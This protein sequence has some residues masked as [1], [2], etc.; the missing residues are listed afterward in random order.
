MKYIMTIAFA[1]L[2]S[3]STGFG[4]CTD[5]D[6]K[7]LEEFDKAWGD[8]AQRGDRA[9]LEN[10]LADDCS[11]IT[12]TGVIT[13]AQSIDMQMKQAE[14]NRTNPNAP[15]TVSDHYVISCSGNSATI[16]HR[17]VLTTAKEGKST[18]Q[19]SRSIHFLEKR[20][21]KWMV[22]SNVNHM[23][24]DAAMLR[25]LEAEWNDADMNH[26]IA[27][28]ENNYASDYSGV[29]SR[30]GALSNKKEDIEDSK[31]SKIKMESL[32]LSELNV[33]VEGD[34]AVVT[35]INHVKGRDDKN[36]AFD[37][38]VRFTDTFIKRSGQ[39]LAWATQGTEINK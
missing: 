3:S 17:N 13:K 38:S 16:T 21:G 35:G 15:K 33:R 32:E 34:A 31:T 9:F 5:A 18:T 2:V 36:T 25:Y 22:V 23:L 10:T 24:D 12:P 14:A 1:L 19:Y 8:A 6:K 27:W 26:D 4:Q 39:W 11:N 7:K 28:F 20:N 37:R 29:S 30:T